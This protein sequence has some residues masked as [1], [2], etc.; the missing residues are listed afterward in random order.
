MLGKYAFL[1]YGKPM[2]AVAPLLLALGGL[3][4]AAHA[5]TGSANDPAHCINNE[6]Q[7]IDGFGTFYDVNLV[8]IPGFSNV[9]GDDFDFDDDEGGAELF[10]DDDDQFEA[11]DDVFDDDDNGFTYDIAFD[12]DG[13]VVYPGDEDNTP[14]QNFAEAIAS[15]PQTTHNTSFTAPT[16][17]STY[18]VLP[19]PEFKPREIIVPFTQQPNQSFVGTPGVSTGPAGSY[20]FNAAGFDS[21]SGEISPTFQQ[22][23][24]A[25]PDGPDYGSCSQSAPAACSASLDALHDQ[26]EDVIPAEHAAS[27]FNAVPFGTEDESAPYTLQSNFELFSLN[28]PAFIHLQVDPRVIISDGDADGGPNAP[29]KPVDFPIDDEDTSVE[30]V[31]DVFHHYSTPLQDE[32]K[33]LNVTVNTQTAAPATTSANPATT[34][35]PPVVNKL[36]AGLERL[37]E[38]ART[39]TNPE[40]K[41][42]LEQRVRAFERTIG[43]L[44]SASMRTAVSIQDA[45]T[46]PAVAR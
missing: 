37:R 14:E 39:E 19:T 42:E 8:G 26:L 38:R 7:A 15:A 10:N 33:R 3:P 6:G 5:C 28:T 23:F 18:E 35:P 4:T 30:F 16:F 27:I 25:I 1:K 31:R 17:V 36:A 40:K 2:V 41:A 46:A 20:E 24:E 44:G 32:P 29:V 21:L 13:N 22:F 34:T 43:H 11:Y 12:E 45:N 9:P